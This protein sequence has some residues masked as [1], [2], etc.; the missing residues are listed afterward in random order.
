MRSVVTKKRLTD[1]EGSKR[2][3]KAMPK[4]KQQVTTMRR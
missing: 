4:I 3:E 1:E 2:S